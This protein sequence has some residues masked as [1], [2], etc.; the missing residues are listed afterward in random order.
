MEAH[1][2]A[3]VPAGRL[4]DALGQDRVL[5]DADVERLVPLPTCGCGRPPDV[6]GSRLASAMVGEV[7]R[8]GLDILRRSRLRR[9]VGGLVASS[10][11]RGD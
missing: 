9:H 7:T 8:L 3:I 10:G 4:R 11:E 5:S 6:A 2:V 1:G